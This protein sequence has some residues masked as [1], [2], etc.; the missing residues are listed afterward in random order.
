MAAGY[1]LVIFKM[2]ST[3]EAWGSREHAA[4]HDAAKIAAKER[5]D[6]KLDGL[7]ES[8]PEGSEDNGDYS[9]IAAAEDMAARANH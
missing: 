7:T 5:Y 3:E 2:F 1:W 6:E 8:D 9:C 4:S